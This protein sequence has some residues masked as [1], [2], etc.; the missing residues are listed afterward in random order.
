MNPQGYILRMLY[1]FLRSQV[2]QHQYYSDTKKDTPMQK[3]LKTF[4]TGIFVVLPLAATAWI[5]Y[6]VGSKLGALGVN[7]LA[8]LGLN[9]K[10]DVL[11]PIV[12]GA[13]VLALLYLVGL[14][15]N[16]WLFNKFL[17]RVDK[18][19]SNVPGIKTIYESVRDIIKL[20]GGDNKQGY[21]VLYNPPN[22]PYKQLGIVTNENPEGIDEPNLVILY[23][24]MGYMI[25]GQ[26]ILAPREHLAKLDM[27][28]ETAMKLAATAF[29]ASKP[30]PEDIDKTRTLP[31][32]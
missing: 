2:Q 24:P 27:T 21:V 8:G 30:N 14:L 16:L 29:V 7:L 15:T 4:M 5:I 13:M 32:A 12:G 9:V 11:P 25:G 19:L 18:L 3:L 28:V 17:S 23:L 1:A 31:G 22:R 6:W 26:I 10:G 20:F